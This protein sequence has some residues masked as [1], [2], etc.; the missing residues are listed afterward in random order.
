MNILYTLNSGNPGGM[1]QH[2][3]D[4]VIGM[5]AKNHNVFV[6]CNNG[7][8]EEWYKKAGASVFINNVGFDI[9][10]V[11]ILKLVKFIKKN[12]IDILHSHELK[13]V[14]NSLL[15]GFFSGVNANISH[16]HTPFTEWSISNFKK[17]VYT[18]F[19]SIAVFLFAD[20]EIALTDSRKQI[21]IKEGI[22][23]DKLVV[24][25][26]AL[27]FSKFESVQLKK[28]I[29]REE[30]RARYNIGNKFVFGNVSRTTEEKNHKLLIESFA[31]LLNTS[32]ISKDTLFLLIAGGGKLE[33][34]LN[35]LIGDLGIASNVKITGRFE[36]AD[37]VKFY[38][39]FDA[40]VF[41]SLAEGFGLV[42]IEA[43][44]SKLPILSSDLEV[45]KEVGADAVYKYFDPTN[46]SDLAEK[47]LDLYQNK[48]ALA[49]YKERAYKRVRE[50]YSIEKFTD[51]YNSLYKKITESKK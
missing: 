45:L 32:Q 37:L 41:P 29:Y 21:K 47:M 8:I 40:F 18:F 9:D 36:A 20:C 39:T 49:G 4:L 46:T 26:N 27:D 44:Y 28:E 13:A 17:R 48:E 16:I 35:T 34:E 25:P 38:S 33:N 24:I 42:L 11:Y 3:L 43:M 5:K 12:N 7:Q 1:E 19:Y 30:I 50:L 51:S 6:W 22:P 23:K 10:P 15:A 14:G 31:K 2:V